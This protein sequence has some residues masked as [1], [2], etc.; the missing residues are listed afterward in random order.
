MQLKFM[1]YFNRLD[2]LKVIYRIFCNE[3]TQY[4][5]ICHPLWEN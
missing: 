4:L 3:V 5:T 2:I 1:F